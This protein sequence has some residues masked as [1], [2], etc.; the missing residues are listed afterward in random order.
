MMNRSGSQQTLRSSMN[1]M[2]DNNSVLLEHSMRSQ[3]MSNTMLRD[4][5]PS[6]AMIAQLSE[7]LANTYNQSKDQDA[8]RGRDAQ[9]RLSQIEHDLEVLNSN[10][11]KEF[12][13]IKEEAVNIE[14]MLEMERKEKDILSEKK[15]KEFKIIQNSLEIEINNEKYNVAQ[16]FHQ[17]TVGQPNAFGEKFF[18]LKMDLAKEKKLR[19][20]TS[21]EFYEDV[22]DKM[23]EVRNEIEY[24]NKTQVDTNEKLA[25]R[26]G[27][28][29]NAFHQLLSEERKKRKNMHERM[30]NM[31]KDIQKQVVNELNIERSEREEMQES[32]IKLLEET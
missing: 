3:F 31:I 17:D 23:N 14:E 30:A 8:A 22:D 18:A 29:I 9:N 32:F 2:N 6:R 28:E 5:S 21:N 7:K 15:A 19:E 1:I 12:A 20:D 27:Q 11:D 26:L 4:K 25:K 10:N 13:A 16:T 24:L